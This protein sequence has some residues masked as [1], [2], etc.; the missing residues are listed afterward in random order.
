MYVVKRMYLI[1]RVKECLKV[2]G[3]QSLIKSPQKVIVYNKLQNSELSLRKE[4]S[5][6]GEAKTQDCVTCTL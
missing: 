5:Y 4:P 3:K 1:L 2:E 6:I